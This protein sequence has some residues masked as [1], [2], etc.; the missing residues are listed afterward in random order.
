MNLTSLAV[1]GGGAFDSLPPNFHF[2]I[3]LTAFGGYGVYPFNLDASVVFTPE[4]A[5]AIRWF[6]LTIFLVQL[7]RALIMD[8]IPYM[9]EVMSVG[10]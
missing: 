8:Y 5:A 4:I 3:D 10:H 7:G 2:D 1:G 6:I 9:R